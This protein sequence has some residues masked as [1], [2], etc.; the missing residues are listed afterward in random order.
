M[1]QITRISRCLAVL[2]NCLSVMA[3]IT[4]SIYVTS[5][6]AADGPPATPVSAAVVRSDKLI[7]DISATGNLIANESVKLR[8]EITGR[9]DAIKFKEGGRVSKDDILVTLDAAEYRARLAVSEAN[10]KLRK[11]NFDRAERLYKQNLTSSQEYDQ[12]AAQLEEAK[13]TRTL[14]QEILKK[15]VLRAPF[16]GILGLRLLSPGDYVKDG[17][18]IVNITDILTMKIDFEIPET[19]YRD[20]Q[21]G[22]P[23]SVLVDSYPGETFSGEVYA[24]AP[25]LDPTSRSVKLRAQIPN[26][27]QRLRPGMFARI[28]LHIA[29][30]DNAL[31]IPEEALWPIGN[32]QFVYKIVDGKVALTEIT[33]G[34]RRKGE[35][36]ITAGLMTGDQVVTAGQMKIRDGAPVMVLGA[37]ADGGK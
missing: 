17:A 9:I 24:I 19:V 1:N 23:L 18:D 36:E 31:L 10:M 15:T 6:I 11:I 16:N 35:V 29:E 30:K 28:S 8:P 26:P 5:A 3:F 14:N 27:D 34:Y 12:A 33:T 13:A 4:G 2:L 20:V 7:V 22:Q 37:T 32:K 21:S 25:A